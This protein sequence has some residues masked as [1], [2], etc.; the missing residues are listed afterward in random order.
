MGTAAR[1]AQGAARGPGRR[2]IASARSSSPRR[3]GSK[4]IAHP[5][6]VK[7]LAVRRATRWATV[8]RDGAPRRRDARERARARARSRSRVRSSCSASCARRSPRSTRK[9]SSIAI[10]S[11]R[12]CS[13]SAAGT[14]CCSTS[15]SRRSSTAPASTTTQ[16]GDVRGT[17]AYMAPERFFGQPAGDRDRRLR[18]RGDPVRDARGP[19]AVGRPRRSRGATVAATARRPRAACPKRSMSRSVA[20]CRRA[21]RIARERPALLDAVRSRGRVD[22]SEPDAAETAR[23]RAR[24]AQATSTGER[25]SRRP[26]H[27]GPTPT[28]AQR[29]ARAHWTSPARA[30][31]RSPRWSR[32]A[33]RVAVV[34]PSALATL[35]APRAAQRRPRSPRRRQ[36]RPATV[37]PIAERRADTIPWG[38]RRRRTRRPRGRARRRRAVRRRRIDARPPTIRRPPRNRVPR[39]RSQLGDPRSQLGELRARSHTGRRPARQARARTAEAS[40]R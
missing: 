37:L 2:P 16:D 23:L 10:S 18:A 19:P 22:A 17:P 32:G 39:G 36:R 9:G 15:A 27:V 20:R 3:S 33:A 31:R 11:P 40:R 25:R 38:A 6:V 35:A 7:V 5:S 29:A 28:E 34:A 12:T 1:R 30:R 14:R 24:P 13:S 26:R 4:Q 21:R 8:P